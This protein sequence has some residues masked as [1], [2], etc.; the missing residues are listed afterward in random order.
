MSNIKEVI[1]NPNK[2]A[3]VKFVQYDTGQKLYVKNSP[4]FDFTN[5]TEIQI[6]DG[7][8]SAARYRFEPYGEGGIV[9]LPDTMFRNAGILKGYIFS[10]DP[11]G[12]TTEALISIG[13]R[14]RPV[15]NE[16][17]SDASE[18]VVIPAGF[19]V[20]QNPESVTIK[21]YNTDGTVTEGTV[22]NGSDGEP[23]APGE[24]GSDG[25][26]PEASVEQT[27]TGAIITVKD[28]RGTTTATLEN[29][30]DGNDGIS[31]TAKVEQTAGG[32][33]VTITD[34][35]GTTVANLTNGQPGQPGSRGQ[36]G[37]SPSINID[38][39]EGGHRLTITDESH[40][41]QYVDVMDG[42]RGRQGDQGERGLR[43]LPG[44]DGVSPTA[45]V[46]QTPTGATVTVTDGDGTTTANLTNG[47][48]GDPGV[49]GIS[50][51]A[52]VTQT[53]TGAR[54]TITDKNGTTIANLTNGAPGS[55]G[56]QGLPGVDG[57]SPIA[58]VTQTDDG[59]E[60]S[61]TDR[62]GTTEAVIRNGAQG[63]PGLNGV[64]P[65]IVVDDI[66]G[67]HRLTIYDEQHGYQR[68]DV[69]DGHTIG[70]PFGGQTGQV[71]KKI[72]DADFD[73]EWADEEGGVVD[74]PDL[75]NKPQI[76]GVTLI[77]NKTAEDLGLGEI[78]E[79][80]QAEYNALT[81]IDPDTA[82][83][84]NDA[85]PA[86]LGTAAFKNYTD[87]VRPDDTGLVMSHVVYSAINSALSSIY[88]P[89][90]N[91]DCADL[92]SSL[93]VDAN[94]GNV[95]ETNDSGTTTALFM[96]GAG[97]TINAGDNV[98]IIRAGA[99]TIM[100][101]LMGNA[102]DLTNY[103]KK[104]LTTAAEGQTTVEGAIGAL[105]TNKQEKTL[106]TPVES[107]STVEGALGHLSS[108]KQPK[109]L[110]TAVE[111]ETTV[112]GALSALSTNKQAKTLSAAVEEQT[113]V[114]GALGAL[115]TNKATQAEVNDIVNVLGA[116]NRAEI[117]S[118]AEF[119]EVSGGTINGNTVTYRGV[120]FTFNDDNKT[121]AVNGTTGTLAIAIRVSKNLTGLTNIIL[122]GCPS[123][124]SASGYQ[125]QLH[126]RTSG[127][128]P[129]GDYD[130]GRLLT[131]DP[132]H[133]YEVMI[134][135][136]SNI[137]VDNLTYKPMVRLASDPDNTYVPYTMTNKQITD[138]MPLNVGVNNK[139]IPSLSRII[140]VT[141]STANPDIL[142]TLTGGN[143]KF[144][145]GAIKLQ[146]GAPQT[147]DNEVYVI[148]YAETNISQ[149]G[150]TAVIA[151][152]AIARSGSGYNSRI[153]KRFYCYHGGTYKWS[154]WDIMISASDLSYSTSEIN[155]GK[156]WID[157]KPIY[158]KTYTGL[159]LQSPSTNVWN[160]FNVAPPANAGLLI[161]SM[162]IRNDN[163]AC[164]G[165]ALKLDTDANDIKY[166]NPTFNA[167][168]SNITLT[169]E[170]TKTTD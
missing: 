42:E 45:K 99:D 68:V 128:Y 34:R 10:V 46:T 21:A 123:G 93:L 88:T 114:E 81:E 76:N 19:E 72:S 31:P 12:H 129:I 116:K 136:R 30:H 44:A 24:R 87:R 73:T 132:T 33:K 3:D 54:V 145:W 134:V 119:A 101:N 52:T 169:I 37:T 137:T 63:Q 6:T 57:Y 122:S 96:Q 147:I 25:I 11:H 40:G 118:L 62:N 142:N 94:V 156:T 8:E 18:E 43:G 110:T 58:T 151:Q 71:L 23:G 106:T 163:V 90:G 39:I 53:E 69:L 170:Y 89:R 1:I 112:E 91:I 148:S 61:I 117:L 140:T 75:T 121:I 70:V 80:T 47:R 139:L 162:I 109:T 38:T 164:E 50:P 79:L 141:E 97:K 15:Y 102:F 49:D 124:G 29:G 113:T 51:T 20:I 85:D 166:I 161:K 28:A 48:D 143:V 32:A 165:I 36:D 105:A 95:Y 17:I 74:Y 115:S 78:V 55:P 98:G 158:R 67:G 84:I 150:D 9:E 168:T 22:E 2:P 153:Y 41:T 130:K 138:A 144:A 65:S 120:T 26:S 16:Y 92:T 157:G 82:Y 7:T 152:I 66:P 159:S 83:F 133:I 60:I 126:D 86:A 131:L 77:G 4:D 155:T 56:S 13:I 125:L 103:Q 127:D 167:S 160:S 146:N 100:F 5:T 104:D 154:P 64:S 107:Q 149:V 135:I 111:S 27:A 14:E 59:A 35:N 108:A